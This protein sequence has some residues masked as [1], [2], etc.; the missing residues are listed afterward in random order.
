MAQKIEAGVRPGRNIAGILLV[1][2]GS[3]SGRT[4]SIGSFL[5]RLRPSGLDFG[6]HP[7]VESHQ[8]V[9]RRLIDRFTMTTLPLPVLSLGA[10]GVLPSG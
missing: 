6:T 5:K 3:H 9:P 8:V 7:V 4:I 1:L 2:M 10:E